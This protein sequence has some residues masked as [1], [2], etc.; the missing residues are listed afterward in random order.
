MIH[1]K[2]GITMSEKSDANNPN[3]KAWTL[4]NLKI[5]YYALDK[6][7]AALNGRLKSLV[8]G[9][10][11]KWGE[12]DP[13]GGTTTYHGLTYGTTITFYTL[14]NAA[15]RQM[16]IFHEFG[17][18]MDNS[19]GMVNAFSRN[20][21]INNPDFIGDDGKLD[22][23]A[24]LDPNNDMIQHPMSIN[25][26]DRIRA[27]EEHWADIFANYVAGNIDLASQPGSAMN[28]FVTGVLAP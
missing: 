8:G 4:E 6:I 22:P 21:G 9:A 14:G 20:E 15:I 25:G 28:T 16:N 26:D 10:I 23:G 12:H 7:N 24:F 1:G 5:V 19:P 17:H 27:Q 18:L 13:N 2:F 11:F 3:A